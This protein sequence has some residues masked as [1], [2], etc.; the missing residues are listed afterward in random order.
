MI[1]H[2]HWANYNTWGGWADRRLPYVPS[3]RSEAD[4]KAMQKRAMRMFY[5]RPKIFCA[6]SVPYHRPPTLQNISVDFGSSSKQ[7]SETPWGSRRPQSDDRHEDFH[8]DPILQS[9]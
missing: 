8:C 3:G 7:A 5:L 6:L 4:I 1:R 2:Y 9:V